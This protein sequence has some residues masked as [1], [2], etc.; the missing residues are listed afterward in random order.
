MTLTLMSRASYSGSGSGHH[1]QKTI[2]TETKHNLQG[3]KMY[4]LTKFTL[5]IDSLPGVVV[6]VA[7]ALLAG[8]L[9]PW[10]FCACS[11]TT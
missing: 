8:A 11:D 2:G 10:T 5:L 3:K 1:T 6:F 4:L 7:T 9:F